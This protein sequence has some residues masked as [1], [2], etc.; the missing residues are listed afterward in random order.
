[1]TPLMRIDDP[2]VAPTGG[3]ALWALGFRP[4]YLLGSAFAALSVMAWALQYGGLLPA[5]PVRGPAWH[6]HEMVFGFAMAIVVGFLFTAVRNWTQHRTPEGWI[7]AGIVALWLA[8][9]ALA[10]TPFV[11]AA[12]VVN[13]A[14]L[15][16]A[17]A[18][19]AVPLV[20]ARNRRNY[21]FIALLLAAAG[22][23]V[24]FHLASLGVIAG[25]AGVGLA[26]GLD[27][28]LV[29][30][31]VVAGRVVPM[32]TNNG[33]PGAGASR[34][35]VVEHAVLALT[36][37]LL[38]ADAF[39]WTGPVLTAISAAALAAHA[40]RFVLWRPWRTG[41][42][43]LVWILHAAYAWVLVHLLLRALA[44]ME[45]VPAPLATHALTVGAIGGMTIGMMTRT[46]RGHTGRMLKADGWE[47][48]A[49]VL[50]MAAALARVALPLAWPSAY[51][52]G[53]MAS[54]AAWAAAFA[55]Y[56]VRYLPILVRPRVDGRPG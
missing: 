40:A 20:R 33:V 54:G 53:V 35:P 17:A 8:A 10:F 43:P 19:I 9:R 21:F 6:G 44:A 15:L 14:F 46:A 27:L 16:A 32:F 7:L 51:A 1:M 34:H 13:A 39:A 5:A 41:S 24:V 3:F 25:P 30:V 2:R 52:T 48:A 42:N 56:F 47:V 31:A 23:T 22:A 29:A 36:L 49:Y 50:V 55:I 45:V 37:A 28:V 18:G 38:A 4:F 12:A 11:A 26:A